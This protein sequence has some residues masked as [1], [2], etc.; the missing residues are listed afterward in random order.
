[1]TVNTQPTI[2]KQPSPMQIVSGQS[3]TLQVVAVGDTDVP[4]SYQWKK[5]SVNIGTDS[6]TYS[7]SKFAKENIGIYTVTV[8][9]SF[10][11]VISNPT[12][13]TMLSGTDTFD[14]EIRVLN[15]YAYEQLA[16]YI[17][18][19]RTRLAQLGIHM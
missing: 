18:T 12:P 1:L 14:M 10:G 17:V 11:T 4:L 7:V 9:N 3:M 13:V 8:T 16:N 5:D 2:T 19:I 15:E 6:P